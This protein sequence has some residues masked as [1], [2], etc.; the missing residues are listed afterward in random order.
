MEQLET[1]LTELIKTSTQLDNNPNTA[2]LVSSLLSEAKLHSQSSWAAHMTPAASQ[3]ALIGKLLAGLHNGNLLSADLYP[4]LAKIET[5]LVEWF[6]HLFHQKNGHFTHGSSYGNLEALWQARERSKVSSNIVYGSCSA[7]YSIVKACRIL[8][9]EYHPIPSDEYGQI[10]IASLKSACQQAQPIAIVATAGT[11]SC[12]AIDSLSECAE[13]AKH[14][15]SWFHVDAAWGGALALL[16]NQPHLT[17]IEQ[18]DSLSFDPHKALGQA[19]PCS[20][21]LY[22]HELSAF[23]ELEVDYLSQT[24]KKTLAGSYG[25][26]LFLPLWLSL[27][28][29]KDELINHIKERLRQAE[30]FAQLLKNK[31]LWTVWHSPTGI[32]CFSTN[33]QQDLSLLEQKGVFSQ[34][35]INGQGVYRAVFSSPSTKAEALFIELEPYL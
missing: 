13:I 27:Q 1:I 23:T 25:G 11:S 2:G 20:L 21:L 16:E 7:H 12:G 26:E 17:G 19:K 18:A 6:S 24:P 29:G 33:N 28:V 3:T 30:L 14:V 4:H 5:Q 10:H 15:G 8:G 9:L 35:K 22:K 32:V 31:T 34:A